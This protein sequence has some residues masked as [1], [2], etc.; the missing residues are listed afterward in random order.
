MNKK[1]LELQR[2]YCYVKDQVIECKRRIMELEEAIVKNNEHKK[3]TESKYLEL[4]STHKKMFGYIEKLEVKVRK[5]QD[6]HRVRE[7]CSMSALSR[8][9]SLSFYSRITDEGRS[10][11]LSI[12][13]P[14]T[15]FSV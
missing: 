8:E 7:S 10:F 1:H 14:I 6:K 5:F 15:I 11:A 12:S 9:N 3:I 4:V 13:G 2:K